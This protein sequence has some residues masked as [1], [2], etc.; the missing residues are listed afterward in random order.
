MP[1]KFRTGQEVVIVKPALSSIPDHLAYSRAV[2]KHYLVRSYTVA[3]LAD[4]TVSWFAQTK[5]LSDEPMD[6]NKARL[7][8][9]FTHK[10]KPGDI[11]IGNERANTYGITKSGWVG[12]VLSITGETM[13]ITALDSTSPSDVY[14]V[15]TLAFDLLNEPPSSL[16]PVEEFFLKEHPTQL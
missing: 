12:K 3:T 1:R 13:K 16:S 7:K 4:P 10:F 5:S 2:I 9:I 8:E 14:H 6:F 15:R 11:V